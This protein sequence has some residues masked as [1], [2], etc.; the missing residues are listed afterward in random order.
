MDHIQI[1][2]KYSDLDV[3]SA[4]MIFCFSLHIVCITLMSYYMFYMYA[5]FSERDRDEDSE[6]ALI[7]PICFENTTFFSKMIQEIYRDVKNATWDVFFVQHFLSQ[8][9][10]K[11]LS[12][13]SALKESEL[14]HNPV[15]GRHDNFSNVRFQVPS[16]KLT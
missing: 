14:E 4:S 3:F 5:K 15:E 12:F 7:P 8:I 16:L 6:G 9:S 1:Y 2:R 13:W 10:L 11:S